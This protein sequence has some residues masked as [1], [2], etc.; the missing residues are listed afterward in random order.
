MARGI[1]NGEP[2]TETIAFCVTLEDKAWLCRMVKKLRQQ[3]DYCQGDVL[4]VAFS[5]LQRSSRRGG[6]PWLKKQIDELKGGASPERARAAV[7]NF[8]E[9]E[10]APSK[11]TLL[12]QSSL[13]GGAAHHARPCLAE[14]HDVVPVSCSR[15]SPS[16]QPHCTTTITACGIRPGISS[17]IDEGE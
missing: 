5:R 6:K 1:T 15:R 2:K 13:H 3:G 12:D 17:E 14:S 11:R 16:S 10:S 8:E 4:R 7:S 9:P